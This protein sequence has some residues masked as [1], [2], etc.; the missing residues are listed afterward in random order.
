MMGTRM[1]FLAAAAAFAA[2]LVLAAGGHAGEAAAAQAHEIRWVMG[3]ALEIAVHDADSTR[4]WAALRAAFDEAQRLDRLLSNYRPESELSRLNAGAGRAQ[5][6]PAELNAYL[7][8]AKRDAERTGGA[9]D[10]TVGPLVTLYRNGVPSPAEI[11]RARNLVGSELLQF[12]DSVTVTLSRE[13]MSLDPGGDGK[14]YAV[15]AMVAILRDA[16][17]TR[18]W[19]DFGRSSVYGLGSPE[20]RSAWIAALPLFEE[21]S[22][23]EIL[24]RDCGMSVSASH[25]P[26]DQSGTLKA[27]IV[28]PRTGALIVERRMA[29]AIGPSATDAEVLTKALI[30]DG[31]AGLRRVEGFDGAEAALFTPGGKESSSPGF[32][33]FLIPAP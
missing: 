15:D 21:H 27:H 12:P 8:R 11:V 14:G 17:I 30:V 13:G 7:R 33:R 20:D 16:G 9:F 5:R 19:I 28:D 4:A 24:L 10:I 29:V 31:E 6:V 25:I 23:L 18:A 3:T 22:H 32:A 2:T 1:Q 26:E